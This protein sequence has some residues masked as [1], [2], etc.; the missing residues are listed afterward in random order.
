MEDY[1]NVDVKRLIS[2]NHSL[3]EE[4]T[5]CKADKD[6]VWDLWKQLQSSKPD[7]GSVVSMVMA[8]EKEKSEKKDQKILEILKMKDEKITE[9][10]GTAMT[11]EQESKYNQT[12]YHDLLIANEELNQKLTDQEH[13]FSHKLAEI[14]EQKE[15]TSEVLR[16]HQAQNQAHDD[17]VKGTLDRMEQEKDD[18]RA[19]VVNLEGQLSKLSEQRSSYAAVMEANVNLDNRIAALGDEM[20]QLT[21][22]C[23]QLR[24][25]HE[26]AVLDVK[27]K[28]NRIQEQE[29]TLNEKSRDLEQK[30]A[31]LSALR[32]RIKQAEVA[33]DDF[34]KQISEQRTRILQLEAMKS[35][36]EMTLVA[37]AREHEL[38][39][40]RLQK[41]VADLQSK[42]SWH[43]AVESQLRLELDESKTQFAT[44]LLVKDEVIRELK[45]TL[46]RNNGGGGNDKRQ[47]RIEEDEGERQSLASISDHEGERGGGIS[48]IQ[49][50]GRR[51]KIETERMTRKLEGGLA[52]LKKLLELKESE[53]VELRRAHSQ[54]QQRYRM[55]KENYQ[56]VQEQLATY[57]TGLGGEP[58]QKQLPTRPDE[59]ELRHEDSD[60]IWKELAHYKTGYESLAKERHEV[61]EEIDIL[62]VQQAGHLATMQ[63][64]Q[65]HLEEERVQK[66][67]MIDEIGRGSG[68]LKVLELDIEKLESDLA[69]WQNQALSGQRV[70]HEL[71]NEKELL[72]QD[73]RAAC[74]ES[75]ALRRELSKLADQYEQLRSEQNLQRLIQQQQ[76]QHQQQHRDIPLVNGSKRSSRE[77]GHPDSQTEKLHVLNQVESIS[78][79]E[80]QVRRVADKIMGTETAPPT[81]T[82]CASLGTQTE[83]IRRS[84]E[85]GVTVNMDELGAHAATN[86]GEKSFQEAGRAK[87]GQERAAGFKKP[88]APPTPLTKKS[89]SGLKRTPGKNEWSSMKQRILSLTQEVSALRQAKDKA[90]KE[91]KQY[92]E[93]NESLQ[94]ELGLLLQKIQVGKNSVQ[95]L[96]ESLKESQKEKESLA[97][98]LAERGEAVGAVPIADWKRLEEQLTGASRECVRLSHIVRSLTTE[99]DD[100][101]AKLKDCQQK[102]ARMDHVLS[103]KKSLAEEMKGKMKEVM[104]KEAESSG[105]LKNLEEKVAQMKERENA[106]KMRIGTLE[107]RQQTEAREKSKCHKEL[108]KCREELR[109]KANLL[110]KTEALRSQ[111]EGVVSEMETVAAM[112]L[113]GLANQSEAAMTSLR[114]KLEKVTERL[115]EFQAFVKTL[116]EDLLRTTRRTE[117]S[118]ELHQEQQW[119]NM[120]SSVKNA[121]KKARDILDISSSDL[122]EILQSEDALHAQR[123]SLREKAWWSRLE[124]ALQRQNA[125]AVP[126]LELLLDVIEERVAAES[127]L[128]AFS[129]T[130]KQ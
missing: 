127:K 91:L 57:E 109:K 100:L 71:E 31:N 44:G 121:H 43:Q 61:L 11:A 3:Y 47:N 17:E 95:H 92:K 124:T 102:L 55:L 125:F 10:K 118:L 9:L 58:R 36:Q 110:S 105:K 90:V 15:Y 78:K 22:K 79:Y 27:V 76:Q 40:A 38:T 88:T 75:K 18:L 99:N 23:S 1:E 52:E 14:T 41:S 130:P 21:R 113:Q 112:Q 119:K 111:A 101:K 2:E 122:E 69:S 32:E 49:T 85:F 51:T 26:D 73:R 20:E 46:A 116:L 30:E 6:F 126:L 56:L 84:A 12:R 60:Q 7:L 45:E 16:A 39:I 65:V 82:S 86:D 34:S 98:Q 13:E 120:S 62:R 5:Q 4:L 81:T 103:Q 114:C 83:E 117:E 19:H 53:L 28:E 93:A 87:S 94:A 123:W 24:K 128:R 25:Q 35:E 66:Q 33:S 42:V 97:A 54:R 59:R 70:A 68:E 74:E 67:Q 106:T 96:T 8:R 72:E 29:Q 104:D 80:E 129:N 89:Q 50:S 77:R 37:H 63:E 108:L 115:E 64:L 107:R 48:P